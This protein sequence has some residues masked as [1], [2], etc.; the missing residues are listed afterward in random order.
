MND[1]GNAVLVC[2]AAAIAPCVGAS[3]PSPGKHRRVPCKGAAQWTYD[4]YVPR[5]Y[6]ADT[7]RTSPVLFLSSPGGPPGTLGMEKLA[8]RRGVILV[9]IN[10]T[11]NNIGWDNVDAIQN[12]IIESVEQT[13]RVHP[14]LRFSMGFSGGGGVSM[15]MA[16]KHPEKHAGVVMLAHS[17]DGDVRTLPQYLAVAFIHAENDQTHG[18]EFA[19][20]AYDRLLKRGNPVRKVIGDWGH[21]PGPL[22]ERVKAM[23]WML[24][25]ARL[26]HPK[27]PAGEKQAALAE[28]RRRIGA[29]GGMSDPRRS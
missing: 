24:E 4:L 14:C 5:A 15:R 10:D 17:G 29:L 16:R 25:L 11:R 28:I 21:S 27:L 26:T 23:D 1:I 7:E 8:E 22:E 19:R 6:A 2:L 18:V 12:A 13:L 20:R 9:S 3:E